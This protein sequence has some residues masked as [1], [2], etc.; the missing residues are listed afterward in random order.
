MLLSEAIK[1]LTYIQSLDRRIGDIDEFK[2]QA[3]KD[4]LHPD[5]DFDKARGFI[6]THYAR[7]GDCIMPYHIN[8][9]FKGY[10]N[11]EANRFA[12][13]EPEQVADPETTLKRIA[14]LRAK[15]KPTD[16]PSETSEVIL[17]DLP[18]GT[19]EITSERIQEA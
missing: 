16:T 18:Y 2:A 6:V 12:L 19:K 8:E 17:S 5:L 4:V 10:R 14:E 11:A 7:S 3:W 1:I 13:P 9:A 15:L